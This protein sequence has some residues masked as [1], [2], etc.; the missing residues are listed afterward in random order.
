MTRQ[1]LGELTGTSPET[2]SRILN[3][4]ESDGIVDLSQAGKVRILGENELMNMLS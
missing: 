2:V 4:M 3:R 1:E